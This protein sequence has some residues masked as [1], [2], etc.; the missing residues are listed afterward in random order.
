[1]ADY[2]SAAIP[3]PVGAAADYDYDDDDDSQGVLINLLRRA[4]DVVSDSD[5]PF[6]LQI[7]HTNHEVLYDIMTRCYGLTPRVYSTMDELKRAKMNNA[8]DNDYVSFHDE[9]HNEAHRGKRPLFHFLATPHYQEGARLLTLKHKGR[10]IVIM[11]HPVLIAEGVYLSSSS[12]SSMTTVE[13]GGRGQRRGR[14]GMGS[15]GEEYDVRDLVAHVN[16]TNYYDNFMTRMLA[17]VPPNVDVTDEHFKEA[18]MILENKFL[19]GMSSDLVETVQKRL[20]LYFGWREV[21]SSSSSSSPSDGECVSERIRH[22]KKIPD[23]MSSRLVEK[24]P[25]WRFVSKK[26][27]YDVKL[28]ARAM[29]VFGDQKMR[30]PIH[31][32]IRAK[33]KAVVDDAFFGSDGHLRD[34]SDPR[35]ESDLPFFWHVP[36]ASGTTVKETLSDCYG[37]VRNEMIRPPS[38]LDVLPE[39]L[40]LNVDLSTPDAVKVARKSKLVERNLADVYVSQLGLEGSTIF[41]SSRPGRAFTI[42]RHPVKL[43]A[44]LFYYRRIATWE[45]T[46][47]PEFNDITLME[48]V[49]MDGY[50]DN[51]MVRMLTNAKL[52]GLNDGHLELARSILERKFVVGMS[53]H[54]DETFRHFEMYYGWKEKKVGCVQFH[55]HSAPSNKNKYPDLEQGGEVWM[56]IANKNKFDMSLYYYALELCEFYHPVVFLLVRVHACVVVTDE[57]P[58]TGLFFGWGVTLSID[59]RAGNA[60]KFIFACVPPLSFR[61]FS[62]APIGEDVSYGE[63]YRLKKTN[64]CIAV[65]IRWIHVRD[66]ISLEHGAWQAIAWGMASYRRPTRLNGRERPL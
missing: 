49:E 54:M 66:D 31:P 17:N 64:R 26:N 48:Y 65:M 60:T 45:P 10:M 29:A 32:I 19:I 9:E 11:T 21:S 36:K 46:Y 6:L 13:E 51:W 44:S 2:S 12:S 52:G 24:S 30:V 25:E 63:G 41:T 4:K 20:G 1:M 61:V 59:V 56:V 58:F 57:M 50:Y 28:Y 7:P 38:S 47:R 39:K 14:T 3:P 40:V 55:L 53:E 8:V 33:E 16:S 5:V 18:R 27:R 43:A 23:E 15:N 62:R 34:V 35:E 42:L 22:A 37:L